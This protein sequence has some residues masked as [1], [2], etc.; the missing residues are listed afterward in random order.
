MLGHWFALRQHLAGSRNKLRPNH[1]NLIRFA[2]GFIR[3]G[4]IPK[5]ALKMRR[6]S[7][8][9]LSAEEA[10]ADP[11]ICRPMFGVR[12]HWIAAFMKLKELTT[13]VLPR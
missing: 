9:F 13:D 6:F 7:P 2:N 3:I 12:A 11:K 1:K 5:N 10:V 4:E 8:A